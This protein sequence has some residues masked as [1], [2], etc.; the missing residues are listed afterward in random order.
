MKSFI[1]YKSELNENLLNEKALNIGNKSASP[2]FNNILILAGGAGSGKGFAYSNIIN[3]EGKR[4]DVDQL[5]EDLK[6]VKSV[7]D[8][9]VK[10][11]GR[12]LSDISFVNPHDVSVYH[13]F[14]KDNKYDDKSTVS[15]FLAQRHLDNKPNVIMDVTLKDLK[16]LKEIV[17]LADLGGY[18]HKNIH[19]C[20]IMNKFEVAYRQNQQRS[21]RVSDDVMITTHTGA[22]QTM[23]ELVENSRLYNSYANGEYWILFNQEAIDSEVIKQNTGEIIEK[24]FYFVKRYFAVKI[25]DK[26][27][28][29]DMSKIDQQIIDK[30]NSYVPK[31]AEW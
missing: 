21:R 17:E 28:F 11:T 1:E 9:F 16:K 29:A 12:Y 14:I 31:G 15:F 27:D 26:G 19:I 3:F 7:E 23:K 30:I 4:F 20:W 6:K 10:Q 25:K 8:K 24:P 18:S 5:K 2:K 22:S 13:Q